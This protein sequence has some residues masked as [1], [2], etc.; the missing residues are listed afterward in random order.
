[1]QALQALGL[2]DDTLIVFTSDNGGNPIVAGSNYPY[3]GSKSTAWEGG[4]RAPA[5][6]RYDTTASVEAITT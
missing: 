2:Y 3:T 4:S 5:F 1:M 6:I